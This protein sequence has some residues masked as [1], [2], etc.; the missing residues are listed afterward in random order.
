M[1][2][3]IAFVGCLVIILAL[4]GCSRNKPQASDPL[5]ASRWLLVSFSDGGR[6]Y[7]V[8][9]N[10]IPYMDFDANGVLFSSSCNIT[11]TMAHF[12]D[13]RL[14]YDLMRLPIA[15]SRA[16]IRSYSSL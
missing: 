4:P 3:I 7:P 6:D 1:G 9:T 10:F 15:P 2:R 5:L 11:Y 16:N 8:P 14:G 13:G 12:E